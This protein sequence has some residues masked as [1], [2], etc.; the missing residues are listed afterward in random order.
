[1][2]GARVDVSV[3][4]D[5]GN[6][7]HGIGIQAHRLIRR[8]HANGEGVVDLKAVPTGHVQL[9]ISRSGEGTQLVDIGHLGANELAYLSDVAPQEVDDRVGL[10]YQLRALAG[11]E[12]LRPR[13]MLECASPDPEPIVRRVP[14]VQTGG[15]F[16][17]RG[18]G[19]ESV[20]GMFASARSAGQV[21][22]AMQSADLFG[23]VSIVENGNSEM[24]GEI[25]LQH[26]RR[27]RVAVVDHEHQC[28]SDYRWRIA[29]TMDES[30]TI[31]CGWVEGARGAHE[32]VVPRE[33]KWALSIVRVDRPGSGVVRIGEWKE[34]YTLVLRGAGRIVGRI[35]DEEGT[36]ICNALVVAKVE[37]SP[38]L[39]WTRSYA[40]SNESG[41]WEIDCIAGEICIQ[42]HSRFGS[43]SIMTMDLKE[44]ARIVDVCLAMLPNN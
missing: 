7:R 39:G 28:V 17:A 27:V 5:I 35:V 11:E 26:G 18:V 33:G 16:Y 37:D 30:Q 43:S 6:V 23:A 9:E 40:R 14:L 21:G 36:E 38:V 13:V 4:L 41:E 15:A 29:P 19:D 44:G 22:E 12:L 24:P 42:A 34:P 31:A 3:D 10:G 8:V 1:M 25:I 20:R 32:I 2:A